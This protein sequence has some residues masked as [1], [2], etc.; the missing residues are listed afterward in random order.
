[1]QRADAACIYPCVGLSEQTL[2]QE[3]GK[4]NAAAGGIGYHGTPRL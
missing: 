3:A 4:V 1:M 2:E